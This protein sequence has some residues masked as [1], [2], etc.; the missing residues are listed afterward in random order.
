MSDAH[1]DYPR[2]FP[3]PS[4]R[5]P[6]SA[7]RFERAAF[8][9]SMCSIVASNR[10]MSGSRKVHAWVVLD[11]EGALAQARVL[12]E[13]L[14]AGND[15]GPLHGIP[16]GIKDI[17]DV[18]GLPTACGAERWVDRIAAKDAEVVA[19]LRRAGR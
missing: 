15:R 17:F 18:K 10:S 12:D 8:P 11:R 3:G 1:R 7:A 9:A 13:E 16:I 4:R 2:F 19:R 6:A 5:L 14:K